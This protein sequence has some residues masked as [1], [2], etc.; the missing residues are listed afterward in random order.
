[1]TN[2]IDLPAKLEELKGS[3]RAKRAEFEALQDA[4]STTAPQVPELA[5]A[6][7][8]REITAILTSFEAVERAFDS[9]TAASVRLQALVDLYGSAR[10]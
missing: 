5:R 1:M 8:E 9:A 3:T 6:L 2:I 10:S 7:M 4:V